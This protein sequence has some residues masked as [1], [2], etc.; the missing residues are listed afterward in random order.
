MVFC[1]KSVAVFYGL[2]SIRSFV[3]IG[4]RMTAEPMWMNTA[5][6]YDRGKRIYG[7]PKGVKNAYHLF[8]SDGDRNRGR[9]DK[10]NANTGK[11]TSFVSCDTASYLRLRWW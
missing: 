7:A 6:R 11:V 2:I 4:P 8:I 3:F 9:V 1:R 10:A 5:K